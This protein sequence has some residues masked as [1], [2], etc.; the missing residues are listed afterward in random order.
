MNS[1]KNKP[2]LTV[3]GAS[4]VFFLLQTAPPA[5]AVQLENW[6]FPYYN[7]A[8]RLGYYSPSPSG[9]FWDDLGPLP[10]S[11]GLLDKSVW[12]ASGHTAQNHWILEPAVSGTIGNTN[13]YFGKN[14]AL[15]ATLLN[16][17]RYKG[18][19]TRQVI[20]VDSR[21]MDDP[22]YP[23]LKGRGVAGRISEAYLQYGF[24]Y[25]FV[26]VGRLDRNWGPFA[27]RSLILSDN[28]YS[29]DGIEFGLHSSFFEFRHFFAA[30][31]ENGMSL[32]LDTTGASRY[33][34]AHSLDFM[35]GRFGTVGIT[36][37][38]VF[39]RKSGIPD[40]QYVNPMSIYFATRCNG[41]GDGNLMEAFQWNLHPFTDKVSIKG[42]LLIDDMQIDNKTIGDQKPNAWGTD[43][44]AFWNDFLP[45]SLPH[46]LSLE[47]RFISRWVYTV[48]DDNTAD[49]QRYTYLGKSLGYPTDDGDSINLCFALSG[50]KYWAGQA[51]ISYKRQGQGTVLSLWHDDSLAQADPTKYVRNALGY[52]IEPSI[53][54]GIVER[55]FDFYINLIGYYKNYVDLQ[56][57]LHNRWVSNKGN[58]VSPLAYDPQISV[59]LGLHYSDFFVKLPK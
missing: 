46:V 32:D 9:M 38:V 44:G 21:F 48:S 39:G 53:P 20:D 41:E 2:F 52:R 3:I 13:A 28:P 1:T 15:G 23:W 54:S 56:A 18:F 31:Q 25:G 14:N 22:Q 29:Y 10:D 27:D 4:A 51:G 11:A 43:L 50:K 55:T 35:L 6:R 33:L 37:T 12:P 5:A 8:S 49:G 58:A 30:F 59:S 19:L 34:T 17:I 45:F 16:D 26:R 36:E 47:Y 40:L 24:K 57:T 7:L 42:Q